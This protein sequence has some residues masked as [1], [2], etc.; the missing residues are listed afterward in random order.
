MKRKLLSFAMAVVM[1][2]VCLAG[3]SGGW[4]RSAFISAAKKYGLKE[5]DGDKTLREVLLDEEES[6]SVYYVEKDNKLMQLEIRDYAPDAEV[7][8]FV[9]AIETIG[10]ND[11][12]FH[13]STYV[14]YLT[15]EDSK[16]AKK[17]YKQLTKN[18]ANPGDKEAEPEKGEKNGVTY[19]ICYIGSE[20]LQNVKEDYT[21]EL[22]YG[23][24]LK[25]NKIVWIR[26]YFDSELDNDYVESICKSLG[27]VSPYTLK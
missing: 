24:Y 15:L 17:T 5:L 13:C 20:D 8:E 10:K 25:D 3:C 14:Y 9:R 12:K 19:T 26:S 21:G 11:N 7:K 4:S 18:F 16:N 6:A 22:A 27:L 1:S 2:A 23:V